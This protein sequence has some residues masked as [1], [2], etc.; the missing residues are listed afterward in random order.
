MKRI[1]HLDPSF[2]IDIDETACSRES[3]LEKYG[4]APE[5]EECVRKQFIINNRTFS[6]IAAVS[7][8]GFVCW[9]IHEGGVTHEDFCS[10]LQ[11]RLAP[12]MALQNFCVIDN[13]SI[14][15]H[16]DTRALLQRVFWWRLFLFGALR[17]PFETDRILLLDDQELHTR[18]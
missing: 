2:C 14:H 4:W 16:F 1:S 3:F 5:G 11:H 6:V 18:K 10:F 12:H 7:P 17:T 9:E 13:A 8:I 15:K